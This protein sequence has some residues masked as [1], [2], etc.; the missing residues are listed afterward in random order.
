[1]ILNRLFVV[2]TMA[3]GMDGYVLDPTNQKMMADI[4]TSSALIGQDAY[5]GKYIK[6]HRKGL[7]D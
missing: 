4:V 1:S 7:L 2:Q 3:M 5:C 6:A